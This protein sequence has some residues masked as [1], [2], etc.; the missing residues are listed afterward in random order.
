MEESSGFAWNRW[1]P[2][3]YRLRSAYT[4]NKISSPSDIPA[5]I[6]LDRYGVFFV[7]RTLGINRFGENKKQQ[8]QN[9]QHGE[10][11]CVWCVCAGREHDSC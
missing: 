6:L 3:F 1:F 2:V 10:T 7:S 9:S 8:Q 4:G 11:E 5:D